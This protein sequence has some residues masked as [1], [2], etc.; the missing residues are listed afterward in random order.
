MKRGALFVDGAWREGFAAD[1]SVIAERACDG[2]KVYRYGG[3]FYHNEIE[4]TLS[5]LPEGIRARV[6]HADFFCGTSP[7]AAGLHGHR[8]TSDGRSYDVTGHCVWLR[9]QLALPADRRRTT[10]V[11]PTLEVA[12]YRVI[13]HELGH[14]VHEQTAYVNAV[15]PI[16][17]YAET[18]HF[19]AFAE[20]F[21][22]WLWR[23]YA[24]GDLRSVDPRVDA[25]FEL[26]AGA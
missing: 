3:A 1:G 8:A 26:I 11:L 4:R 2:G 18:S 19:E 24:V 13:L 20:A 15:V 12:T 5:T 22:A 7:I 23:A 16:T 6:E 17:K 10:I 25:F 14:V 9:H 21:C